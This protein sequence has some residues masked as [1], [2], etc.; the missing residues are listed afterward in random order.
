MRL[1]HAKSPMRIAGALLVAFLSTV[2]ASA[3]ELPARSGEMVHMG[4]G[5]GMD[6]G[7]HRAAGSPDPQPLMP[8]CDQFSGFTSA[9]CPMAVLQ[10]CDMV[11]GV[12]TVRIPDSLAIARSVDDELADPPPKSRA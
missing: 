9:I 12:C 7:A 2:A 4:A 11:L 1:A 10:S 6:V 8:C 3:A 5:M